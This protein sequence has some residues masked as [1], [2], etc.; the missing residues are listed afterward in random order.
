MT[1]PLFPVKFENSYRDKSASEDELSPP[2]GLCFTDEGNLLIADDFN[3]RIQV[4]DCQFN[5]QH[6]FASKGKEAGQLHYPKGIAVDSDG[7]IYVADCWNHRIQKFDT[8]GNALLQFGTCGDGKGEM[9]EP[10]DILVEPS[11]NLIVVERYNHR[12]QFFDSQGLSLGWIGDRGT[13]FEEQLGELLGTPPTLLAP[14]LFEFPTSI[15]KDSQGN[16]FITDSGNHRVRK[17]NSQWQEVLS[18]GEEGTE[19]GQ[20][21]Y[22]M[23]VSVAPNDLLYIADLNNN[24]IQTFTPFGQHLFNIDSENS[25][26]TL[27]APGITAIDSKGC[28]YTGFTF[29]TR[30]SKYLIPLV[31]QETLAENLATQDNPD[32]EHLF[33]QGR[34]LE[35][36]NENAK[37]LTAYEK[38]LGQTAS[39]LKMAAALQISNLHIRGTT[40]SDLTH[41]CNCAGEQLTEARNKL[42]KCFLIWQE[43]SHKFVELMHEEEKRILNDP[44]GLRDFNRELHIAELEE[45]KAYRRYRSESYCHQK[46]VQQFSRFIYNFIEGKSPLLHELLLQQTGEILNFITEYL[47]QKEKSE[48]SM[49]EILGEPQGEENRLPAFLSRYHSNNKIMDLQKHLQ[50]ELHSHWSN[51]RHLAEFTDVSLENFAGKPAGDLTAFAD[52]FKILIGFQEEPVAYIN[53]EQQFFNSLDARLSPPKNA[54]PT[55]DITLVDLTPIPFDTED[56]NFAKIQQ[57]LQVESSP[58]N[59]KNEKLVW[60]PN[61]FLFPG[62]R[63]NKKE[64]AQC[65]CKLMETQAIY[66]E[67]SRELLQQ[68]QELSKKLNAL[69]IQLKQ[70]E[71]GDKV[72]PITIYENIAIIKFQSNLTQ[73]M[74]RT[75]D[76]N[77]SQNLYRLVLA[78]AFLSQTNDESQDPETRKFFQDFTDYCSRQNQQTQDSCKSQKESIFK[79]VHLNGLAEELSSK[80][81]ISEISASIKIEQDL[82]WESMIRDQFTLEDQRNSRIKTFL[83][84]L[85]DFRDQMSSAKGPQKPTCRE[86]RILEEP[87]TKVGPIHTPQG[88]CY[89]KDGNLLV[90]D[91]ENHRVCKYSPQGHYNFHFGGLGNASGSLHYPNNLAIDSQGSIYVVENGTQRIK[92]FNAQGNY[93]FQFGPQPSSYMSSISI[94]SQDAVWVTVPEHNQI[95][96]FDNKGASVRTL[97]N[98]NLNQ[99]VSIFCLPK[100][101]YLVGDRSQSLLKHFDAQD[102]L[103]RETPKAGWGVDEIYFLARH[104]SHG[105]YGSDY[106]NNQIV[107][108][109]DKLEMQSVFYKPGRRKGQLGKV[110]GLAIFNNELAVAN[111]H[112]G[113]VQI[114]DLSS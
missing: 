98:E 44:V 104:P 30:I 111:T 33:Y 9:N 45:K 57:V 99:P 69:D 108:L 7:N 79:I 8:K 64:V 20:F 62:L 113:K 5:F 92:K 29:D 100:G 70:T 32:P 1:T 27:E 96:I 112:G 21:Q 51:L 114:F 97:E 19:P 85:A 36:Q 73:R 23:S 28:L 82:T 66:H 3:H 68:L 81:E 6:S 102:N 61:E 74:I 53:L 95:I 38:I 46:T 24:R 37:A 43:Q 22:P 11:G 2:S 77:Q 55:T 31:S 39:N 80:N 40:L 4:Y 106:W 56:I 49:V 78:G 72:T 16:Y 35:Q 94:D 34:L 91:Y 89:D 76:I 50:V 101:E 93:L 52:I 12:I 59:G 90:T 103:I 67:K 75:L 60:G 110:G 47:Q 87:P 65:A 83:D 63:E 54:N 48:A 17:F 105:I 18:F 15:A 42:S 25:G 88:I 26:Q 86:I 41:A 71:A 10:Y 109:N 13:V 84:T 14:V 107:H 58:L